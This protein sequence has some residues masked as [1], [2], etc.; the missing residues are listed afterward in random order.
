MPEAAKS[1]FYHLTPKIIR[2]INKKLKKLCALIRARYF[3]L[4][5]LYDKRTEGELYN[6]HLLHSYVQNGQETFMSF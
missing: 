4:S 2:S 3:S 5:S 1:M 6:G